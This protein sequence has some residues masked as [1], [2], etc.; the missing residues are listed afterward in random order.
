MASGGSLASRPVTAVDR[1]PV[2]EGCPHVPVGR[3]HVSVNVR[4]REVTVAAARRRGGVAVVVDADETRDARIA[5][6]AASPP[7]S[8]RYGAAASAAA[9]SFAGEGLGATS[10]ALPEASARRRRD[11]FA[12]AVASRADAATAANASDASEAPSLASKDI[13]G[14]LGSRARWRVSRRR[15]SRCPGACSGVPSL[16]SLASRAPPRPRADAETPSSSEDMRTTSSSSEEEPRA[17]ASACAKCRASGP[18]GCVATRVR[19]PRGLEVSERNTSGSTANATRAS[20]SRAS[21]R[22]SARASAGA[23]LAVSV[24]S[25]VIICTTVTPAGRMGDAED[26]CG[27]S[28]TLPCGVAVGEGATW[29]NVSVAAAPAFGWPALPPSSP[30]PVKVT[31]KGSVSLQDAAGHTLATVTVDAT[32]E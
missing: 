26:L 10:G 9:A 4:A 27:S 30:L 23:S 12:A 1:I 29:R 21:R 8:R 6:V 11:C 5:R 17:P 15:V 24:S 16:A 20:P 18:S 14:G 32:V 3:P 25:S 22:R 2:G 19:R 28:K 13:R 7:R 31:A